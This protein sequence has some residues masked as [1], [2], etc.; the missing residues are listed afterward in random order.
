MASFKELDFKDFQSLEEHFHFKQRELY[1]N[2]LKYIFRWAPFKHTSDSPQNLKLMEF[3]SR[4]YEKDDFGQF[5][6]KD[7]II[8]FYYILHFYQFT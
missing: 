8:N 4:I 6:R 5:N 2:N 1:H 3:L 7:I